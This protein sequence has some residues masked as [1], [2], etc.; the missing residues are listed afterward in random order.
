[1]DSNGLLVWQRI[2]PSAQDDATLRQ[3]R[4]PTG[5]EMWPEDQSVLWWFH[6]PQGQERAV[7]LKVWG[8]FHQSNTVSCLPCRHFWWLTCRR[9]VR[10]KIGQT[11]IMLRLCSADESEMSVCSRKREKNNES[12][13]PA[14]SFSLTELS[15]QSQLK[16]VEGEKVHTKSCTALDFV[17]GL[18]WFLSKTS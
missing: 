1:M 4:D 13:G 5:N 16:L 11:K 2:I 15:Q 17:L 3:D 9:F 6:E 8:A 12:N 10:L 18:N 14:A 7:A